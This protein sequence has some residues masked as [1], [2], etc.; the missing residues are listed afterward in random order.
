M[1][2]FIIEGILNIF[3]ILRSENYTV[4]FID[5]YIREGINQLTMGYF[6][7]LDNGSLNKYK[8]IFKMKKF[9]DMFFYL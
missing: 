1:L 9:I 5:I 3:C 4:V 2:K 7:N 8:K 6:D